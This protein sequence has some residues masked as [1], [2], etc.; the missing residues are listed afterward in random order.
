MA[1]ALLA[2]GVAPA[3]AGP[4]AQPYTKALAKASM[5]ALAQERIVITVIPLLTV[6]YDYKVDKL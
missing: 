5:L 4:A 6:F 3:K 1:A 2:G